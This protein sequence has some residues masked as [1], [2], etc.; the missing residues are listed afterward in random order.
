[1]TPAISCRSCGDVSAGVRIFS[2]PRLLIQEPRGQQRQGLVMMPRRSSSSPDSRPGPPPPWPA[3]SIPRSDAPPS[4]PGPTPSAASPVGIRQIIIMLERTVRLTFP[5][6][7]QHLLRARAARRASGPGPAASPPR[8][9]TGL[10]R[11]LG[12]R[13]SSRPRLR[14]AAHQRSTRMNGFMDAAPVPNIPAASLQV[15]DQCVRGDGQQILFAAA[16]NSRRKHSGRP[17]SSSPATQACGNN[18]PRSSR[19]PGPAHGGCGT[20]SSWEP[21]PLH[22]ARSLST[23]REVK[24]DIDHRMFLPRDIR[25]VDAHLAVLDLAEPATP[26]PG[27]AHRFVPFLAKA[28]GSKTITPSGSPRRSPTCRGEDRE[29]G[30]M[31]PVGLADE[32]L[33]PCVLG[34]ADKRSPRRSCVPGGRASRSDIRRRGGARGLPRRH[35]TGGQRS[36]AG[37]QAPHRLRRDLGLGHHLLEPL[38]ISHDRVDLPG[39]GSGELKQLWINRLQ[40]VNH[41]I[42]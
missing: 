5:R 13:S 1:M 32:P 34:R 8:P 14:H 22:R 41:A 4:P 25:H 40:S 38:L 30:A 37:E 26:L 24:T 33:H 3:R 16:R 28:E 17:I 18:E 19:F 7:E 6:D 2:P 21:R 42:Q 31:F 12:P 39:E 9:S 11:H 27:H 10:S 29:R 35:R 36:P 23:P 20:R 15:T